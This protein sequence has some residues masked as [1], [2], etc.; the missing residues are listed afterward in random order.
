MTSQMSQQPGV[1]TF[2]H[3]AER[4]VP[5]E[6]TI[7]GVE[8]TFEDGTVLDGRL[9]DISASGMACVFEELAT[10]PAPE[11]KVT[12]AKIGSR[13]DIRAWAAGILARGERVWVASAPTEIFLLAIAFDTPQAALVESLLDHLSPSPYVSDHLLIEQQNQ[14]QNA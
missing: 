5:R 4:H 11:T 9:C 14:S 10:I 3:R 1:R 2:V 12:R 6:G 13:E 8:V 7:L